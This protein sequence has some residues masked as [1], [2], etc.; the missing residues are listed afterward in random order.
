MHAH[1]APRHTDVENDHGRS[2]IG[3][4]VS[5]NRSDRSVVD[6]E[7]GMDGRSFTCMDYHYHLTMISTIETMSIKT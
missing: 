5:G 1:D 4:I 7:A 3:P 6:V 2:Y